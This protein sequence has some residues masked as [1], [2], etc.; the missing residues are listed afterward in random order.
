MSTLLEFL[1]AYRL[2]NCI[3]YSLIFTFCVG[4]SREF[5]EN[6][7]HFS[8]NVFRSVVLFQ[9]FLSNANNYMVFS[10]HLYLIIV[11]CLHTF[12]WFQVPINND[13]PE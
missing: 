2:E 7:F 8:A 12:I 6:S 5:F 3:Q 10:N 4:V 11:V 13:S 1:F 9:V